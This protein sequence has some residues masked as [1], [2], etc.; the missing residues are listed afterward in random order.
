MA[1]EPGG[2]VKMGRCRGFLAVAVAALLA[3]CGQKG[4]LYMP[5][6]A[7]QIFTRPTQT[8]P[9]SPPAAP[10]AQDNAPNTPQT[11]DSPRN[12]DNPARQVTPPPEADKDKKQPAPAPR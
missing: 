7:T 5:D 10:P 6:D 3:G 9:E 12:P 4:P 2:Q 11:I 8:P 1:L